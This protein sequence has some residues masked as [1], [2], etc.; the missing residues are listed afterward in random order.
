MS[1]GFVLVG[2]SERFIDEDLPH[3]CMN[4]M[5]DTSRYCINSRDGHR[6]VTD[7]A[8]EVAVIY[9]HGCSR[10]HT[11]DAQSALATA[12]TV[13]FT[14]VMAVHMAVRRADDKNTYVPVHVYL[15]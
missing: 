8:I 7:M 1:E 15:K 4:E 13:T 9:G 6:T 2:E 10:N 5:M 11:I 12:S 3:I 14:V